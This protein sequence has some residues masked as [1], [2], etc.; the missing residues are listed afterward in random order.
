MTESTLELGKVVPDFEAVATG[1]ETVRLSDLRG[2]YVIIYFYPKDHT[3]GC[4]QEGRDFRD[5]YREF[6][7]L[8]AEVF[9]VSRDSLKTHENFKSKQGFPFELISDKEEILCRLFG[10]LKQKKMFGR[11]VYGI[12]RSTFLLDP[13]GKLA[14]EWRKVKVKGH[15]DEVLSKLRALQ[16]G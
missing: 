9:G 13:A 16:A 5:H 2:K 14:A 15:V 10:V 3:P 7:S 11:D 1:G 8:G 12:E 6:Q 4:T